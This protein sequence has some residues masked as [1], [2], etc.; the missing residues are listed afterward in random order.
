MTLFERSA[1]VQIFKLPL[2]GRP[3]DETPPQWL[4]KRIQSGDLVINSFGGFT[5]RTPWGVMD[6]L[7]GDIIV[8]WDDDTISFEKPESFDERFT[9]VALS[10]SDSLQIAA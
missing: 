7:A 2:W 3:A 8:L 4:V 1:T 5:H 9:E 10:S 6:C